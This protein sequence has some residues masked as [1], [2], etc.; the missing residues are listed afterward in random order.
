MHHEVEDV[1]VAA[2]VATVEEVAVRKVSTMSTRSDLVNTAESF[3]NLEKYRD[4]LNKVGVHSSI[5]YFFCKCHCPD[6]ML[7]SGPVI[8]RLRC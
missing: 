4:N 2:H 3:G 8:G 7:C 5:N 1:E 6:F